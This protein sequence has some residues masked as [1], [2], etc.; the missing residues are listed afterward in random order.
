MNATVTLS[1]PVYPGFR[2]IGW[3]HNHD[4]C[5][6]VWLETPPEGTPLYVADAHESQRIP[7]QPAPP[8]FWAKLLRFEDG[9][10]SE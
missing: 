7:A 5:T 9:P 2:H 8:G 10:Q 1:A 6:H 4:R 3:K